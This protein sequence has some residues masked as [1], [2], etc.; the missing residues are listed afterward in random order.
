MSLYVKVF[1]NFYT[2]RKTMRLRALLGEDAFWIPPRIWAYAAENQP[3]GDF[4][5][6]SDGELAG[7]IGYSKDATSMLQAL[8]QAGF[9]DPDRK[10][11]DW[12]EHNSFH[13][14]FSDRAR[15]AAIAKWEKE[16]TKEKEKKG[17]EMRRDEASIAS[18]MLQASPKARFVPPDFETVQF[19]A[20]KIG[21]PESEALK[22]FNYYGSNGWR[23]GKNPMK[24]WAMAIA[25]WK[26]RWETERKTS[27]NGKPEPKSILE[28][29]MDDLLKR[30][31]QLEK[32]TQ[33]R[34]H[35]N[36]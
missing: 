19:H 8:L 27:F 31:Q 23:V 4:S 29:N 12:A 33:S 14:V 16:R 15:C 21:L 22:F 30:A 2:H 28:Q 25:G 13:K 11:H 17:D 7:L 20:V 5:S 32:R 10:V 1:T 18:S 9:M 35:A 36:D 24:N 6:Y 3:D 26:V 34:N